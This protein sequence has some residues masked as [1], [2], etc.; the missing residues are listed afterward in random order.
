MAFNLVLSFESNIHQQDRCLSE[1]LKRYFFR[2][3]KLLC[4]DQPLFLVRGDHNSGFKFTSAW[5]ILNLQLFYNSSACQPPIRCMDGE[6]VDIVILEKLLQVA[7]GLCS[8]EGIFARTLTDSETICDSETTIQ[9]L[10]RPIQKLRFRNYDRPIQ[11]L[12]STDS[13]TIFDRFRNYF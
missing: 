2:K 4:I 1:V 11:K 13:E 10:F 3:F 6:G 12:F 5:S 7:I 9:K 8:F